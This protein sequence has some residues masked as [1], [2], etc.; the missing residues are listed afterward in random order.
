MCLATLPIDLS[1]Y[2]HPPTSDI[3]ARLHRP[4]THSSLFLCL[5]H[6][7]PHS[8]EFLEFLSVFW[9]YSTSWVP[10]F[11]YAGLVHPSDEVGEEDEQHMSRA[12]A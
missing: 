7:L 2:C 5:C 11:Y 8:V 1:F 10:A 12:R 4:L 9:A 6:L 3:R